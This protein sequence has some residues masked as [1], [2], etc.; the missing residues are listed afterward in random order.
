MTS[1][2]ALRCFLARLHSGAGNEDMECL[3]TSWWDL[4]SCAMQL[5]FLF[6]SDPHDPSTWFYPPL[7]GYRICHMLCAFP[8]FCA[9]AGVMHSCNNT[10]AIRQTIL[11]LVSNAIVL[12]LDGFIAAL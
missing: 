3:L 1:N 10:T 2:D 11:G 5:P 8:L 6:I 4:A 7:K 9:I 12:A